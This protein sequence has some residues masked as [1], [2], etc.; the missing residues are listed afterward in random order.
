MRLS[1][2]EPPTGASLLLMRTIGIRDLVLGLG[3][4]AAATSDGLGDVRRWTMA[5]LASDSLDTVVSLASFRSIGKRD[6]WAAAG[7]AFVFVCGDL[8]AGRT[9]SD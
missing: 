3:T 2:T 6:S 8:Y 9:V 4:V 1:G 5:A 7:L